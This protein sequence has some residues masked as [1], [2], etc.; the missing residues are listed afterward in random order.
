M[1]RQLQRLLV[2]ASAIAMVMA[3]GVGTASADN[4]PCGGDGSHYAEHH[5]SFL[6]KQGKIGNSPTGVHVPG[7]I[8]RGFSACLGV[9]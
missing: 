3:L 8:H 4:N 1:K 5:I 7:T 9:H 2:L 6:A